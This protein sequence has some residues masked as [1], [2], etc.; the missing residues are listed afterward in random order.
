MDWETFMCSVTAS[1]VLMY[2][3]TWTDCIDGNYHLKAFITQQQT[4]GFIP[5]RTNKKSLICGIQTF[6]WVVRRNTGKD[7]ITSL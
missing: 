6:H 2:C 1:L 7:I 3:I 5:E 4:N